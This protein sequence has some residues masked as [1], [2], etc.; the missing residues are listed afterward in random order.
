MKFKGLV[1]ALALAGCASTYPVHMTVDQ[2]GEVFVGTARSG[3]TS[4]LELTNAQGLTC[5]GSYDAPISFDAFSAITVRGTM[6]C[7]DGRSGQWTIAGD[8]R[9]G[10]GVGTLG[11]KPIR[12]YFGNMVVNQQISR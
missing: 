12:V 1:A 2:T 7:P 6:T 8:G 4:E 11:D 5:K 9:G 10:Q 3:F